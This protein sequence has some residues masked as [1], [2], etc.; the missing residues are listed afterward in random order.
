MLA[1]HHVL[2]IA[3]QTPPWMFLTFLWAVNPFDKLL[4]ITSYPPRGSHLR[5]LWNNFKGFSK[6][7]EPTH[8]PMTSHLWTQDPG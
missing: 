5:R 8:E 1:T 6:H 2:V 4:K 3:L 7:L